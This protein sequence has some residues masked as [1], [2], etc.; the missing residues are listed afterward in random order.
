MRLSVHGVRNHFH[1]NNVIFGPSYSP[2]RFTARSYGCSGGSVA[3]RIGK[4]CA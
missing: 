2:E 3:V 1:A 4:V